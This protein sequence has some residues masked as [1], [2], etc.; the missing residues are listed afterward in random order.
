MLT[1]WKQNHRQNA[2]MRQRQSFA[3]DQRG[4][5]GTQCPNKT[6]LVQQ[7]ELARRAMEAVPSVSLLD[8][9]SPEI[10]NLRSKL[11]ELTEE[12]K[13]RFIE[14]NELA[15]QAGSIRLVV[16]NEQDGLKATRSQYIGI[17][18]SEK[19]A[20]SLS[21]LVSIESWHRQILDRFAQWKEEFELPAVPEIPATPQL[22]TQLD[23]STYV[24]R[25]AI[26]QAVSSFRQSTNNAADELANNI[27]KEIES[28]SA[29]L[30][31]LRTDVIAE[32]GDVKGE[33]P[34]LDVDAQKLRARITQ[35]DQQNSCLGKLDERIEGGL[36][37]IDQ[38]VDS[39]SDAWRQM[40]QERKDSC[41][42]INSSMASFFV[43]LDY[44]AI[45]KPVDELLSDLRKGSRLRDTTVE[46]SQR[47]IGQKGFRQIRNC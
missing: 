33:I 25:D 27:S 22:Q 28:V 6:G 11:R 45:S 20:K 1:R 26:L 29:T 16:E 10:A 38:I 46:G 5:R 23:I 19:T 44:G 39:A 13:S 15:T 8:V 7:T 4:R 21:D 34:E 42:S 30:G 37:Q 32:L 35:L 47:G 17:V 2:A 24:P 14:I 12:A 3:T 36:C 9:H 41:R 40:R 18:G 43:S 31:S